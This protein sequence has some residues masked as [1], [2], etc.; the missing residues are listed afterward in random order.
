MGHIFIDKYVVHAQATN[1]VEQ[2]A[3]LHSFGKM[4]HT[5]RRKFK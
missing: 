4:L 5:V 3:N 2:F 1:G